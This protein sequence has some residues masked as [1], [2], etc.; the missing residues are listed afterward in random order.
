MSCA[1]EG[2][3]HAVF[4]GFDSAWSGKNR[5]AIAHVSL[6]DGAL[7]LVPPRPA[8]FAEAFESIKAQGCDA[9][10]HVIGIDQPL[11]VA[12]QSGRRPVERILS[13][14]IGRLKSGMLSTN[15]GKT[16]MF[17][18]AAPIWPFL[19]TLGADVNWR[20]SVGASR[21]CFV[22]EVYPAPALAG[23]FPEFLA[24]GRLPR[25]NPRNRPK[26]LLSDWQR[27][28]YLIGEECQRWGIAGAADWRRE[29]KTKEPTKPDQD[30]LDALICVLVT[31]LWWRYG[32]ERSTVVGDMETGYIVTPTNPE[33]SR[34]L[35]ADWRRI[36]ASPWTEPSSRNCGYVCNR[37]S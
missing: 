29:M 32:H 8:S 4:T 21:G 2:P 1:V 3:N 16:D 17:G 13:P 20:R 9:E 19:R 12:N 22:I 10:L 28:C 18:P 14:L 11:I 37:K 26:F 30:C 34:Q 25:Y 6:T 31:Y 33:M 23:L 15:C 7:A 36:P 35:E 27:V 24:H 5:G